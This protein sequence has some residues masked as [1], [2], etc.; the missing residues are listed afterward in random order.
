MINIIDCT[1]EAGWR[2]VEGSGTE[3]NWERGQE[4]GSV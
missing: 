4:I 3:S 2:G 1:G